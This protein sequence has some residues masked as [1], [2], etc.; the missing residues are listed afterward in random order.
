MYTR[1][2][3]YTFLSLHIE[4]DLN[5][6]LVGDSKGQSSLLSWTGKNVCETTRLDY[7]Y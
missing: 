2:K 7:E 3:L 1:N 4:G 5:R 6:Q